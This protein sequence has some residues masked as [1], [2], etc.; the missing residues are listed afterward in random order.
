MRVAM[1][2]PF[3]KIHNRRLLQIQTLRRVMFNKHVKLKYKIKYPSKRVCGR[4]F[5]KNGRIPFKYVDPCCPG[6]H[7]SAFVCQPLGAHVWLSFARIMLICWLLFWC[8]GLELCVAWNSKETWAINP[9]ESTTQGQ[10]KLNGFWHQ[11]N[12]LMKPSEYV[13]LFFFL[14]FLL[15]TH[16]NRV[17]GVL[18]LNSFDKYLRVFFSC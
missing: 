8:L 2:Y 7:C 1:E 3:L 13:A 16:R 9:L 6:V 14:C 11:T 4:C 10:S 5:S 15:K 12:L 18:F 17:W